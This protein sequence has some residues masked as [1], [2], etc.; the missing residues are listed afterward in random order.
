MSYY[1]ALPDYSSQ[2]DTIKFSLC[3]R[4]QSVTQCFCYYKWLCEGVVPNHRHGI[5][6]KF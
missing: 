6:T 2:L 5:S 3:F 4:Q 1:V